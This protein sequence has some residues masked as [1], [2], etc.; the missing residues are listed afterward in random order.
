MMKEPDRLTIPQFE[1]FK[2]CIYERC[3]IKID[4]TK[5]TLITN[6]LKR[7]L[8]ATHCDDFSAYYKF[9]TSKAG[10]AEL[11]E[12]IDALT[13][14]ET[15]FFR[16]PSH[17]EWF[18]DQFLREIIRDKS[19]GKRNADLRIWSAACSSGEEPYS[20]AMCLAESSMLLRGWTIH[21]LGSDISESSLTKAREAIYSERNIQELGQERVRRHFTEASPGKYKLRPSISGM[22]EFKTHNLMSRIAEQ[23]FDCIWLRNVLIYFDRE[24]KEKVIENLVMSLVS[25][26]YLVVGPSEGVY[27]MLG[28][29]QRRTT[30]LYQKP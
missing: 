16:T 2:K 17:F 29:L 30:F 24:S 14:N 28:M 9:I 10:A 13:T 5:I 20:L 6:R 1:L 25:G 21:L 23:P 12:F 15:A 18:K 4:I 3:G 11:V 19:L 8:R 26:G 7:R 22:V 27:D